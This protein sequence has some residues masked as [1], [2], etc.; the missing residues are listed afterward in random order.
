MANLS[1]VDME[2]DLGA[3]SEEVTKTKRKISEGEERT[4]LTAGPP[5]KVNKRVMEEEEEFLDD[6]V[7]TPHGERYK[8]GKIGE[9]LMVLLAQ[10]GFKKRLTVAGCA[11]LMEIKRRYEVCIGEL[12]DKNCKLE[13]RLEESRA[14]VLALGRGSSAPSSKTSQTIAKPG[15][16]Q[17]LHLATEGTARPKNKIVDKALTSVGDNPP[18]QR[19]KIEGVDREGKEVFVEIV[20]KKKRRKGG[21]KKSERK[22][23]KDMRKDKE[24]AK[25][26][27]PPKTFIISKE[28]Q[29]PE[30]MRKDLWTDI[31]K[32]TRCPK[33]AFSKVLPGGDLLVKP[34]DEGTYKVLKEIEAN[35]KGMRE[36]TAKRPRVLIYDEERRIRA[37]DLPKIIAEQN[38]GLGIKEG[39]AEEAIKP[40]FMKGPRDDPL[41]W[42]VCEVRPDVYSRIV[43]KRI[44]IGMSM[45]R[46]VDFTGITQCN[47]CQGFGHPEAK[48]NRGRV[49][50]GYCAEVGHRAKDCRNKDKK[51]R[52]FNCKEEFTAGHA[53]CRVRQRVMMRSMTRTDY[54]GRDA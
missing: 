44:F 11:S 51:P 42:W 50:C 17:G 45:C 27:E 18:T 24:E 20:N 33:V 38:A 43:N 16:K 30:L 53:G 1:I 22:G 41:A 32:K 10:E 7:T 52:C 46:V 19:K 47:A 54:G 34:A 39:E 26:K 9:D 23:N 25:R 12:T 21:K 5:P 28:E 37:E 8:A 31:L 15:P 36:E 3:C 48:C 29:G 40:A 35:R 4:E 6:K 13:G 49:I 14:M 2:L